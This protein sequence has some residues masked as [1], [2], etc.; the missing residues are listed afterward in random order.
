VALASARTALVFGAE[1]SRLGYIAV[2]G[3]RCFNVT[4]GSFTVRLVCQ[5]YEGSVSSYSPTLN[6]LFIPGQ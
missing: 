5:A 6:A 2:G 3:T 4:A 1:S